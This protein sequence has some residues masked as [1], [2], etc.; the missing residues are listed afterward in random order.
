MHFSVQLVRVVKSVRQEA[1]KALENQRTVLI[2]HSLLVYVASD[3][4]EMCTKRHAVH[5]RGSHGEP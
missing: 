3:S 2:G 5:S 4:A 1:L